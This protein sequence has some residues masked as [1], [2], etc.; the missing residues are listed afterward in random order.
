MAQSANAER[1]H[2]VEAAI[3]VHVATMK[4]ETAHYSRD[5]RGALAILLRTYMGT[6]LSNLRSRDVMDML[7]TS[8]VD[9]RNVTIGGEAKS[10]AIWSVLADIARPEPLNHAIT[11]LLD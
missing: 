2:Q 9:P 3:Q 11:K 4:Q 8:R 6:R 1:Q 5:L 7:S 10:K